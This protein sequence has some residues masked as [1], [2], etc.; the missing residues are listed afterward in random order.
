MKTRPASPSS[1]ALLM[2]AAVLSDEDVDAVGRDF[3][4]HRG[5]HGVVLQNPSSLRRGAI[6][7]VAGA[8]VFCAGSFLSDAPRL[9]GVPWCQ[10]MGLSGLLCELMPRANIRRESGLG[11]C[12]RLRGPRMVATARR[13]GLITIALSVL[14]LPMSGAA[15]LSTSAESNDVASPNRVHE[16]VIQDTFRG[17][18]RVPPRSDDSALRSV[19]EQ[20]FFA[21]GGGDLN[22]LLALWSKSS[23]DFGPA[24]NNSSRNSSATL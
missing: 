3:S 15:V 23:P 14:S 13:V 17:Q 21:Y 7:A 16:D 19:V 24:N 6:A 12:E 1:A 11:G 9:G 5:V 10:L 2:N 22:S 8:F 20:S 18:D 4:Q